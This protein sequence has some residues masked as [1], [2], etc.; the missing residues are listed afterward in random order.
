V[1]FDI[2]AN[3]IIHVSAKDLGCVNEQKISIKGERRVSDDEIKRMVDQAKAFEE[4]DRT[5]R[6]EIEIRNLADSAVFNAEKML[7]ESAD[8]IDPADREK[9][10]AGVDG[11]KSALAADNTEEIKKQMETL[12]EAVY[13]VTTR[14]YQ[15]AQ[16]EREAAGGGGSGDGAEKQDDTV[17]DADYTMKDE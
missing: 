14:I 12:T 10:Q 15:K 11:V 16:A 2:D 1:T 4:E 3:G 8:K 17:V 5:K 9:I 6:E 13:A 7:K